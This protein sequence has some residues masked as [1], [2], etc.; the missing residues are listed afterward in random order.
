MTREQ[1]LLRAMR[2]ELDHCVS[3]LDGVTDLIGS[4]KDLHTV[5]ANELAA[6]MRGVSDHIKSAYRE[7]EVQK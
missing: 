7:K 4:C 6:L 2:D 1:R 3:M 5:G